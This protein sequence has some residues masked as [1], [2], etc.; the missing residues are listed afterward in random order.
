[1][2][3][4]NV[5]AACAAACALS[6]TANAATVTV[7]TNAQLVAALK[8]AVGG[9]II[10]VAPGNYGDFRIR[11]VRFGQAVTIVAADSLK[12]PVFSPM[13]IRESSGLNLSRMV[14][15]SPPPSAT[16]LNAP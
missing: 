5:A 14:V 11:G 1:M 10:K 7:K 13:H 3:I 15:K 8:S 2:N 9:D 12:P 4:L 6:C 16:A